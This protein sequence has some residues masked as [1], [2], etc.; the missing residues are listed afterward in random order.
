M[1]LKCCKNC[2]FKMT[3]EKERLIGML[4]ENKISE[5]DYKILSASLDKKTSLAEMLFSILINPFQRIAGF[6][7]L[8]TGLVG[9][10]CMSYFGVIAKVYFPG[11]LDC[12]NASIV[13][14]PKIPLSFSL[15]AYQNIVSWFVLTI[16][17]IISAKIFQQ[18]RIRIIDFFGTVALSRFPFLI[19]VVFLSIVRVANPSFMDIDLT[20]GF[21]VQKSLMTPVFGTVVVIC[22]IWQILTYFYALKVSSGLIGKKLWI[23]FIG[24][25]I[26]G[27]MISSTLTVFFL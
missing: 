1:L 17:F 22:A 25:I 20:R 19:L 9:I 3:K 11:I 14:N 6:Y 26:L 2:E 13:K 12:L 5:D 8:A 16:L 21:Q 27:E 23:S 18:K 7:S 4:K 15:L 24:S 10:F